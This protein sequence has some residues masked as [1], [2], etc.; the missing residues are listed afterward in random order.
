LVSAPNVSEDSVYLNTLI[1]SAIS[2]SLDANDYRAA[3]KPSFLVDFAVTE[4][5]GVMAAASLSP[6][7]VR[8]SWRSDGV[9]AASAP[10]PDNPMDHRVARS[11]FNS[12]IQITVL[13]RDAAS[14]TI[15][16]EGYARQ[17]LPE[18]RPRGFE[19]KVRSMVRLIV[20]GFP[21]SAER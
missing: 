14:G 10:N 11:D 7:S 21:K 20:D 17:T 18:R 2:D 9:Y 16:W 15:V 19:R 4:L 5:D 6:T 13:M 1:R 12:V 3:E 8:D